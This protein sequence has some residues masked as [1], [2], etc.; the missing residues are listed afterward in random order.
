MPSDTM[1]L[2]R[3]Q[4]TETAPV[5]VPQTRPVASPSSAATGTESF[6]SRMAAAVTAALSASTEPTDRS[7]PAM[8]STKV[9]PTAITASAGISLAMETKVSR[10]RKY[11]LIVPN[12]AIMPTSTTVRPR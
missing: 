6:H 8:I 2:G 10:V 5:T 7:M 11:S 9:M 1:K 12:S 3:R 4:A